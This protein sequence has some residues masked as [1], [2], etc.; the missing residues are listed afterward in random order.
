MKMAAVTN[1]RHGGSATELARR[2]LAL[3]ASWRHGTE[4]CLL[5]RAARRICRANRQERLQGVHKA[6]G[7]PR[8]SHSTEREVFPD[9]DATLRIR[10][11]W[12]SRLILAGS[13]HCFILFHYIIHITIKSTMSEK[14]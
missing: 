9:L 7:A 4:W 10:L 3:W 2:A 12:L 1:A 8:L 11:G 13:S 14:N 5:A 6:E